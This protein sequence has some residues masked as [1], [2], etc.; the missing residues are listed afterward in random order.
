M[1]AE[2]YPAGG[3]S[4]TGAAPAALPAGTGLVEVVAS[5]GGVATPGARY[6]DPN[7]VAGGQ[8][9]AG[10]TA[11]NGSLH[12]RGTSD[13]TR[14]NSQVIADDQVAV[15]AGTAAKPGLLVGAAGGFYEASGTVGVSVSGSL[16][17]QFSASALNLPAPY[18]AIVGGGLR[19]GAAPIKT[20]NY[21]LAIGTDHT[22]LGDATGGA[23]DLTLPD[24]S[25]VPG[26]QFTT[27]KVDASANVVT[28]KSAGGAIDGV[29]AATG[30]ALGT[31]GQARTF[32]SNGVNWF[33]TGG[34]L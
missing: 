27:K 18:I 24:A 8:T 4:Q 28:T 32:E 5:V 15:P 33:I 11:P 9:I 16:R 23:F 34:Y 2:G 25:T 30:V 29:A 26:A 31:Q 12:L 22:V 10:D 6:V 14:T 20:S 21:T 7:G 1:P 3:E 17:A 13:A 19:F